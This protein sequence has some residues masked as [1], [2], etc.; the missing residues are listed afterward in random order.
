[1]A[2]EPEYLEAAPRVAGLQGPGSAVVLTEVDLRKTGLVATQCPLVE[3]GRHSVLLRG[4]RAPPG[5]V[6]A[7]SSPPPHPVSSLVQTLPSVPPEVEV[8]AE[9]LR[10]EVLAPFEVDPDLSSA[11]FLRKRGALR[12]RLVPAVAS[13]GGDIGDAV[14]G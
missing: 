3:V 1:M 6:D 9:E 11:K 10:L 14:F 5:V 12:L 4:S 13:G 8:G 7:D 2:W